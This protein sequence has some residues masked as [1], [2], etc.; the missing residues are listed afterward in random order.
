MCSCWVLISLQ[1]LTWWDS[2]HGWNV[3]NGYT[4]FRKDRRGSQDG[5]VAF[6]V[7]EHLEC[8]E[9][10]LRVNDEKV[11][12]LGV[13]IKGQTRNGDTVV[14]VCYRPLEEEDEVGE[15]FYRH[16]SILKK[17]LLLQSLVSFTTHF[18]PL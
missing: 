2:S 1:L 12:S 4:L 8:M 15:A 6:Y 18:Q 3:V 5:G 7:R 14:D 10:C 11:R 13:R 17:K 9:L 16:L